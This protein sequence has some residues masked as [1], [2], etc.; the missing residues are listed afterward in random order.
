MGYATIL[1]DLDH[2]LLDSNESERLA[3]ANTMRSFGLDEPDQHLGTYQQINSKLWKSVERGEISPNVVKD[4][5]FELF[6]QTIGLDADPTDMGDHYMVALGTHGELFPGVPE[7][8]DTVGSRAQLGLITNGL[9]NVQRTRTARLG[10]DSYFTGVSISGE[11]GVA[12]PDPAIFD[13]LM[14]QL[15]SP[16]AL[17][18]VIVGD[19]LSSDIA[20]GHNAGIATCWYN[21]GGLRGDATPP[22]SIEVSSIGELPGALLS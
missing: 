22:P 2:T 19:S 7:M 20:G 12:K 8:L 1:F 4:R 3:F 18:T 17:D 21:P 16:S 10:L 5:R 6:T 13:H 15:G 9:G 14:A 11:I